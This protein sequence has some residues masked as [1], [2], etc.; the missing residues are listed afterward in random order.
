MYLI[1]HAWPEYEVVNEINDDDLTDEEVLINDSLFV[2]PK[3]KK[4]KSVIK[5]FVRWKF[6]FEW[7]TNQEFEP[8]WETPV[9]T[10]M[11]NT[12]MIDTPSYDICLVCGNP[13]IQFYDIWICLN[14]LCKLF[15]K[16]WNSNQRNWEFAPQ[17]LTY[18]PTFLNPGFVPKELLKKPL[19]F[20]IVPPLIPTAQFGFDTYTSLQW[21]GYHCR[22]CGRV[23]CRIKWNGWE[24]FNCHKIQ[25]APRL[26]IDKSMLVDP[27]RPV[28][29]GPATDCDGSILEGSDIF[30]KRT[31]LSDGEILMEYKFPEGGHVFHYVSNEKTNKLP[32]MFLKEFQKIDCANLKRHPVKQL[33]NMMGSCLFSRQFTLNIGAH[34]KQALDLDTVPWSSA[35]KV[36][37]DS[38]VYMQNIVRNFIVPKA[39]FNQMLSAIYMEGQKMSWHDDGDKGVGPVIATLSLGSSAEMKFR[40]KVKKDKLVNEVEPAGKNVEIASLETTECEVEAFSTC[41]D[42]NRKRKLMNNEGTFQENQDN[43]NA[44]GINESKKGRRKRFSKNAVG[45]KIKPQVEQELESAMNVQL[46]PIRNLTTPEEDKLPEFSSIVSKL[47]ES[48]NRSSYLPIDI[49]KVY[50]KRRISGPELSLILHHGDLIV[51]NGQVLQDNYDQ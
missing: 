30:R 23:S 6:R 13:S 18:K 45:S 35:P 41:L 1:T 50:I 15:W 31:V 29:T 8:W 36:C 28:F 2:K 49:S 47:E 14:H 37:K 7:M 10:M 39:K 12:L 17:N 19:P 16:V 3:T 32:D 48:T 44:N 9:E 27:Y 22:R 5:H 42:S 33:S 25:S 43:P 20:S 4:R 11:M 26:I 46:P 21:K 38:F 24:C 34:Y 51:M 40:R